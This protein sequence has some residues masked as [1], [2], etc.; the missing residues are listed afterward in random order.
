MS[1]FVL[2]FSAALLLF[3]VPWPAPGANRVFNVHDHGAKGDGRANDRA[4]SPCT[5]LPQACRI[6]PVGGFIAGERT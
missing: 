1:P 6:S 2:N 4:A 3:A 5:I